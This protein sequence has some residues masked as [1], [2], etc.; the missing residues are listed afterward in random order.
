VTEEEMI[1]ARDY[2]QAG[3]LEGHGE[4]SVMADLS[5]GDA[6]RL[7]AL[8]QRHKS[9]TDSDVA[10]KILDNWA[11]YLPKFRK[12]MP[13]DY[14]KALADMAKAEEQQRVAAE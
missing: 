14:R 6:E 8:I 1:S 13:T 7:K 11:A 10:A 3:D 12:V 2:H 5:S 4:V 9:F